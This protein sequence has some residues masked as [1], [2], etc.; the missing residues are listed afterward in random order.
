[1][2]ASTLR[3]IC[4]STNATL[5]C[6]Q[7]LYWQGKQRD[8]DGWI[9]KRGSAAADDPDGKRSPLNQSIEGET[10]LTYKEQVSAR[11]MLRRR[12]FLQERQNRLQHLM[13]FKLDIDALH[14]AWNRAYPKD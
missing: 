13:Y 10:G 1:M 9:I 12:G 6:C 2:K 7:L 3:K 8:K 5:F 14:A 11:K 4:G